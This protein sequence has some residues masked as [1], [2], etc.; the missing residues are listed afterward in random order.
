MKFIMKS[1]KVW[2][3]ILLKRQGNEYEIDNEIPQ[4]ISMK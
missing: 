1:T 3:E 4:A 2:N